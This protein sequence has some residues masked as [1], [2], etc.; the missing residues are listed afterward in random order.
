MGRR[1]GCD[2]P[3]LMTSDDYPAYATAIE[4]IF[5]EPVPAPPYLS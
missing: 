5:S 2:P 3:P 4:E 1:V